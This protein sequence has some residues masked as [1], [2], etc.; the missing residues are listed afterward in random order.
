[1]ARADLTVQAPKR[2]GQ[3][4]TM[5]AA[6]ADGHMFLNNGRVILHVK[7]ADTAAKTV[8]IV[9]VPEPIFGRL[10]DVA[11]SVPAGS[12][13]LIGPFQPDGFNQRSG[14][15]KGKVYVNYSA[16]TNVT[17]GAIQMP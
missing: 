16:V 3:A 2:D 13:M 4:Y 6:N 8:T 12:E 15:D 14:A 11:V 17:V 1:M 9:S 5:V 7:N 10:G